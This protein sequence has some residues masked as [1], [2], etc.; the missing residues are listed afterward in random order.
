MT[1]KI[2]NP[3]K[4]TKSK[5]DFVSD[6]DFFKKHPYKPLAERWREDVDSGYDFFK[7]EK[8]KKPQNK[9]AELHYGGF[10]G[11]S[12]HKDGSPQSVH[13]GGGASMDSENAVQNWRVPPVEKLKLEYKVEH[14]LKGNSFW[15]SEDDFLQ[16][17]DN[18]K[19]VEVTPEMNNSISYRSNT[20][21]KE[22]L[23]DLIRGYASY[24]KYRNEQTID[25][26]YERISSGDVMDYPIVIEFPSGKKRVFSGNT[27]MDIAYQ[28]GKNPKVLLVKAGG[29]SRLSIGEFHQG[30]ASGKEPH[31]SGTTQEEAHGKGKSGKK[32]TSQK[33]QRNE[34][35]PLSS[36]AKKIKKDILEKE[37]RFK[38]RFTHKELYD[39]LS[40]EGGYEFNT[41]DEGY[42][43]YKQNYNDVMKELEEEGL[44]N[45]L[46][47]D[48]DGLPIWENDIQRDNKKQPALDG[49]GR[50][51]IAGDGEKSKVGTE[52]QHE[53]KTLGKL[54]KSEDEFKNATKDER[55]EVVK[56]HAIE[57][58]SKGIEKAPPSII[59]DFEDREVITAGAKIN[60]DE[61]KERHDIDE[62]IE[63]EDFVNESYVFK[64]EQTGYT[65]KVN[66]VISDEFSDYDIYEESILIDGVVLDENGKEVGTF[67]R[68]IFTNPE[69]GSLCANNSYFKLKDDAQGGGFGSAFYEQQE[70]AY[71]AAG[72]EK[73]YVHANVSDGEGA[74]TWGRMGF[75]WEEEHFMSYA[76]NEYLARAD[77][78]EDL[79]N[80]EDYPDMW[81]EGDLVES[82]N[83]T[84]EIQQDEN[85]NDIE[86]EVP[87]YETEK[88]FI[89]HD[90]GID[91]R[92]YWNARL[93]K[94]WESNTSTPFPYPRLNA[95]A[96]E[97]AA[98]RLPSKSLT[99]YD[100]DGNP[101][102]SDNI[103]HFVLAGEE[104]L[105]VKELNP[106]SDTY[107]AGQMY[108]E[109]NKVKPPRKKKKD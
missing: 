102:N 7:I 13:G 55:E 59:E 21:S 38:N 3:K 56:K 37:A 26:L 30:G 73:V 97:L 16:A 91:Q 49:F 31:K 99:E 8:K 27:R 86:V 12:P 23:L 78:V 80:Y 96:Y 11:K 39:Y 76:E 20:D 43:N 108:Y 36:D 46:G 6:A 42:N 106:N 109:S 69:D 72:I 66:S 68:N 88:T 89:G 63:L 81:E 74:Y 24:P 85:G 28:L 103:A 92:K 82:G 10:D 32:K 101:Y 61:L 34:L 90:D 1:A 2:K 60:W 58:R 104:W 84:T 17:I 87:E 18:A 48:K 41:G 50:G 93:K 44:I 9:K 67:T 65:T 98:L 107:L 5:K 75:T 64:H 54:F 15:D 57:V 53:E 71:I 22:Q 45:V 83:W 70:E 100:K 14:E 33:R 25:E 4:S 105:G 62:S 40:G 94:E 52:K 35:K 95:D 47:K 29:A 77:S 19:I 51:D 79:F